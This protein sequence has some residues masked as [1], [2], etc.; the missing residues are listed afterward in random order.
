MTW[1]RLWHEMPTDPKWRTIARRSG[2][3]ISTVL[4]VYTFLLVNASANEDERGVLKN[5]SD[6]DVASSLDI[7]EE[8]VSCIRR[9]MQGR[10]LDGDRLTGWDKRQPKREDD[11][12]ERVR[13]YREQK[14][15]G[16]DEKRTSDGVKRSVT[17]GNAPDTE[18]SRTEQK[19]KTPPPQNVKAPSTKAAPPE[20]AD[21]SGGVRK[22]VEP[23][24]TSNTAAQPQ[25][26]A[27]RLLAATG[28]DS[29]GAG[30]K[31]G[32]RL[33]SPAR[34]LLDHAAV[35]IADALVVDLARNHPGT[36]ASLTK[37][38]ETARVEA[39]K[40]PDPQRW[41]DGIRAVHARHCQ[42]WAAKLAK[43]PGAYIPSLSQWFTD[44]DYLLENLAIPNGNG[45]RN[46]SGATV[47]RNRCP[48]CD[49][50]R[51]V[52]R[53]EVAA[54]IHNPK[55][56]DLPEEALREPCPKCSTQNFAQ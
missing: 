16:N 32:P 14:R 45:R 29:A 3:P 42:V 40:R 20:A 6:E 34:G 53:P 8:D 39:A 33:V 4:S 37:G 49:D 47:F 18:Q 55:W 50:T 5:W 31:P 1:L 27:Q 15:A 13:R 22:P 19:Q 9:E 10:V 54:D 11:S 28:T 36:G 30:G 51:F 48:E 25:P 7:S 38:K 17:H 52:L 23:T 21:P 44:G 2:Q 12:S 43:D 56:L 46:G 35:A 24:R 26:Q 41:A